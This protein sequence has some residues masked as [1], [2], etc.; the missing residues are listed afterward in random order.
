MQDELG[1]KQFYITP[2]H[3][4]SY[5]P[6]RDANTLFLDPRETITPDAYQ[7][8]SEQ[9]F[10]RSGG[11]LYRPHCRSCQACIPSRVPVATFAAKRRQKRVLA[12]NEDLR[13]EIRPAAFSAATYRLYAR[14]IARRH[15]DGDMYPPSEDQFRSFL[16]SQ[17]SDTLFVCSYRNEDLIAV[18][19]TDRQPRGLSA[20]YTFFEPDESRRSLGVWSILQQIELA[21][22]LDLPYLYLG[23]WIRD[24]SKMRYKTDYRPVELFVNGRWITVG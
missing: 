17:W 15:G 24:S 2:S 12:R 4:C 8:L 20:I 6:H 9:G 5:L 3:P 23:Y 16:L 21:R 1:K 14:Y 11:H 18:A 13:I 10:R 19:V 7:A 22:Q